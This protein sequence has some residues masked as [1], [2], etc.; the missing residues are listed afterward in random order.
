MSTSG[1]RV[2]HGRF[3]RR[4]RGASAEPIGPGTEPAPVNTPYWLL[5][6]VGIVALLL[7]VVAFLLWGVDGA[8]TLFDMIVAFCT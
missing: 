3:A 6:S 4:F 7:C 8:G 1:T 2:R 5:W